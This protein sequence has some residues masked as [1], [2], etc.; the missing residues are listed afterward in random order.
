V[1]ERELRRELSRFRVPGEAD[2][3]ERGWRVVQAAYAERGPLRRRHVRP[4]LALALAVLAVLGALALTPPGQAVLD[5]VR[6]AIGLEHAR[7]ALF[8][9]PARGSL[10]VA[11]PTSGAWVVHADGSKRR[12]GA[13]TDASWSPFGRFVVAARRSEL[14][15]LEPDG[16]VRWT[17]ARPD[18]RFPRWGGST[19]D[20]RIAYLSRGDLRVVA[21]DGTGDR[22]LAN[23]V[24]GIAPA[25]R[26]GSGFVLTFARAGNVQAID[27]ATGAVLWK[28]SVRGVRELAWS[29]DGRLL[30]VRGR[31]SLLVLDARGLRRFD[32]LAP[33]AAAPLT[34]AALSPG[35]Q[36]V[37]F[38]QR[39]GN[40]SSLWL[41]PTLRP[42]GSA[43]RRVFSGRGS[44][45]G[46]AWSPD[47]RWLLVGWPDA[48]QWLFFRAAGVHAIRGVSDIARQFGGFPAVEGWC[49]ASAP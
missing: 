26:P 38:V 17:L 25:W 14:A 16:A 20:T 48:D 13:F 40:E 33:P 43:A 47:G 34:A 1:R 3:L 7:P 10:L 41:I 36:A 2:A 9:L 15:A 6:D 8:S 35:A 19:S 44:F 21:G 24:V 46:L 18:I 32:L 30:L 11:A 39:V 31:Q 27:V 23:G 45:S 22:L 28:H 4:R 12:L 29:R 49:C 37:A 42:D 5:S